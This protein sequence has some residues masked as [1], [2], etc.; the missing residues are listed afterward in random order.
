[1]DAELIK[2]REVEYKAQTFDEVWKELLRV[3]PWVQKKKKKSS[4]SKPKPRDKADNQLIE[5]LSPTILRFL[6]PESRSL[7]KTTSPIKSSVKLT[8]LVKSG[9]KAKPRKAP[10]PRRVPMGRRAAKSTLPTKTTGRRCPRRAGQAAGQAD[11]QA[12]GESPKR[13][14]TQ[15]RSGRISVKRVVFEAG[16]N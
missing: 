10:V 16:T 8:S 3:K 11:G 7:V 14:V 13:Q 1:M 6:Q 2:E 5:Q 9:S 12:R 4:S 15:T